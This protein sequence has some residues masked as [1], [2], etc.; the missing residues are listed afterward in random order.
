MSKKWEPRKDFDCTCCRPPRQ[1]YY[2][3][4]G[5]RYFWYHEDNHSKAVKR[6]K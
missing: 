5:G 3:I 1:V 6:E 2:Q 4:V